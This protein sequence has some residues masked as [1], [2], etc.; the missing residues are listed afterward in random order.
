M[1]DG[2]NASPLQAPHAWHGSAEPVLGCLW[3]HFLAPLEG[4]LLIAYSKL[5]PNLSSILIKADI[6]KRLASDSDGPLLQ[7]AEKLREAAVQRVNSMA[8][9]PPARRDTL[10]AEADSAA[11]AHLAAMHMMRAVLLDATLNAVPF[12]QLGTLMLESPAGVAAIC[13]EEEEASREKV[14]GIALPPFPIRSPSCEQAQHAAKRGSDHED[15]VLEW[16]RARWPAHEV[17][18]SS[19]VIGA[20]ASRAGVGGGFKLEFDAMVLSATSELVAVVE[21][22]AGGPLYTD[23]PKLLSARDRWMRPQD[24]VTVRIG[25]RSDGATVRLRVGA[26][27]PLLVYVLGSGRDGTLADSISR[28]ARL[29]ES[30]RLLEAQLWCADASHKLRGDAHVLQ[31]GCGSTHPSH[32]L[33]RLPD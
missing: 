9:L 1:L 20:D 11:S 12:A 32:L 31:P 15:S 19:Y 18:P 24:T 33:S 3:K 2:S 4:K 10:L 5:R 22:K 13:A 16:A 8:R 7:V 27:A 14:S 26:K 21:A 17:L 30:Q 29:C 23:I 25:R 6:L 28:S